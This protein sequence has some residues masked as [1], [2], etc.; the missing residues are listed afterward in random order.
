MSKID[1]NDKEL[2]T[3]L[4]ADEEEAKVKKL[5]PVW[6][7]S[8]HPSGWKVIR[9]GGS[10]AIKTFDTQLEAIDFAKELAKN[11]NGRYLIHSKVGKIR[12]G[13]N[14]FKDKPKK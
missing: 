10:K 1:K 14:F 13:Q 7:I 4:R 5:E 3:N 6:H 2:M 12:A 9:Q 11:N 8:Q